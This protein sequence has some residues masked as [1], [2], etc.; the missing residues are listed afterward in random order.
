[1]PLEAQGKLCATGVVGG[2][3][4]SSR[5]TAKMV[6]LRKKSGSWAAALQRELTGYG[7]AEAEAFE[8]GEDFVAEVGEFFNVVDEA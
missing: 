4:A 1:V 5:R 7:F 2:K 3:A 6:A 8:A